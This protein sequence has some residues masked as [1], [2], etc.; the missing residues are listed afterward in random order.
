MKNMKQSRLID[1]STG[2]LNFMD[3]KKTKNKALYWAM[4]AIM[5]IVSMVCVLPPLYIMVS[6][7][8]TTKELLQ[9]PIQWF[10]A[11]WSIEKFV[12]I[13]NNL[14][15]GKYYLNTIIVIVG[16]II[17]SVLCNG[18]AGYVLSSLKPK[19]SVLYGTIIMWTMLFPS[20]M[21]F[22][23]TFQ[24]MVDL[25]LLHINLTNTYWPM[26]FGAGANAFQVLLYKNYFDSISKSL[27]EAATLDGAGQVKIFSKIILP[28]GKPI[29]AV[30]AIFTVTACWGDFLFPYLIVNDEK[31]KTI[32]LA[33]YNMSIGQKYSID[34]RLVG[35]VFAIVPPIII[36]FF[37]QKYIM[38]GLT[39]GGVKE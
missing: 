28:L 13:W 4:F 23:A 15:F 11:E 39:L 34:E 7:F 29:I 8:K 35:I 17:F 24:N 19:G 2:I 36:F 12:R 27:I 5:V 22:V 21:S 30:D 31:K 1:K 14:E 9:I 18:L 38:G 6:S 3:M 25:P 16:S 37:L 33:I 26:W 10:P 20:S 32:M